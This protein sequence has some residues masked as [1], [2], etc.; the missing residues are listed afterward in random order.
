MISI[1][2]SI[3]DQYVRQFAAAVVS[4]LDHHRP[5]EFELYI[6]NDAIS[7]E[8]LRRLSSWLFQNNVRFEFML[9]DDPYFTGKD[10]T[11][12]TRFPK[13]IFYRFLIPERLAHLERVLYLDADLLVLSRLDA[14][15]HADLSGYCMGLVPEFFEEEGKRRLR[16]AAISRY[17]NTGVILFDVRRFR[18]LDVLSRLR[19][20]A[21]SR[22]VPLVLPDQDV[23]NMSCQ[24]QIYPLPFIF[25]AQLQPAS[26]RNLAAVGKCF[27]R[28]V[29]LHFTGNFKPWKG[30]RIPFRNL[31]YRALASTPWSLSRF[32]LRLKD[33]VPYFY[34]CRRMDDYKITRLL[35]IVVRRKR[36]NR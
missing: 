3:N 29:I 20:A 11:A 5:E 25:N 7:Q 26:T 27:E 33:I 32:L 23:L 22:R 4:I 31:Y 19:Q 34:S 30:K 17:Y 18:T 10:L 16:D 28:I 15:F 36:K 6:W 13:N 12:S 9:P 35:G 24:D 1:C 14:L 8:N 21:T 2:F